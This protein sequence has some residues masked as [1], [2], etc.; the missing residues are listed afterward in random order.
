MVYK[1][2]SNDIDEV[3]VEQSINQEIY[4][5][6]TAVPYLVDVLVSCRDLKSRRN[7]DTINR[8]INSCDENSN[9]D[10]EPHSMA[11]VCEEN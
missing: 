5:L 1:L 7:P 2:L 9:S 6:L 4:Y 11:T 10:S 8:Y 3:P